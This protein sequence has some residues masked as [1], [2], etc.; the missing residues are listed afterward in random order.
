[1]KSSLRS[2]YKLV[3]ENSRKSHE[4]NK[5]YY[6]RRGKERIFKPGDS[7]YLFS[8]AKK[9]GQSSKFWIPWTGPY[10]VAARI[11]KLNYCI[12]STQGKESV[13]HVNRMKRAYKQGMLRAKGK[14]KCYRKHRA[15]GQELE[16]DDPAVRAPGPIQIPTPQ[17]DNH[18][19]G[20]RSPNRNSPR[21]LDTP[22]TG[23]INFDAPGSQRADPTYAPPDTTR[24]RSELEATR[25]R[26]PITRL[27]SRLQAN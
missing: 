8:P 6:D 24:S 13:V 15:R 5:R 25:Q 3:R 22:A 14:G 23:P 21:T 11:S 12:K 4:T 2:A 27:R 26:P 20:L 18:Q 9:P 17:V 19:P 7:V 1:L 10:V 16:E